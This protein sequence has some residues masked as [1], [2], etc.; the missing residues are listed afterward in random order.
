MISDMGAR[1]AGLVTSRRESKCLH[2][3]HDDQMDDLLNNESKLT[4]T[5]PGW[6]F[7]ET[8]LDFGMQC[9][10]ALI[11]ERHFAADQH[12]QH[13]T[14]APQIH[15]GAGVDFGIEE[16]WRCK[17]EGAAEGGQLG[18][19]GI[20]IGEAEVDDFDVACFGDEDVFDF[21]ICM[22]SVI[23]RRDTLAY[24]SVNTHLCVQ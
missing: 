22:R 20:H 24:S 3:V 9:G 13:N 6:I 7:D 14:K 5:Q 1:A 8:S 15:F 11:V 16:L 12:I 23:Q 19:G 18:V 21:E 2:S 17:V 10:H 4:C